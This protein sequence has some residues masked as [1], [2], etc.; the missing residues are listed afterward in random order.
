MTLND[1]LTEWN[2]I[3][4]NRKIDA[5]FAIATH[6]KQ[7]EDDELLEELI[8]IAGMREYFDDYFGTEGLEI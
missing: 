8:E 6:L 4:Y 7:Y 5:L 2:N 3:S 1:I